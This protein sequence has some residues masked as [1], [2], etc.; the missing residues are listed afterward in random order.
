MKENWEKGGNFGWDVKT[1]KEFLSKV[2]KRWLVVL[3]V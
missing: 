2:L 3:R 1:S